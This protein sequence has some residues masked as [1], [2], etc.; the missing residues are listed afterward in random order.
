MWGKCDFGFPSNGTST[1]IAAFG[2]QWLN[3]CLHFIQQGW[4]SRSGDQRKTNDTWTANPSSF[5]FVNTNQQ[6]IAS[7]INN[8]RAYAR[9]DRNQTAFIEVP[10]Q[11]I[12]NIWN[13]IPNEKGFR[14][15]EIFSGLIGNYK[16]G[17]I[18]GLG[19]KIDGIPTNPVDDRKYFYRGFDSADCIEFIIR[20]G[21]V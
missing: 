2:S 17:S 4:V 8:T 21:I 20:L 11:D 9:S 15:N 16:N 12:L 7:F 3:F 10:K 5:H 19:G 13:D 18:N 6:K 1:G 14:D